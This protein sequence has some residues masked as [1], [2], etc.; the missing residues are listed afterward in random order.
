MIPESL[1]RVALTAL[2]VVL[3][4]AGAGC[5]AQVEDHRVRVEIEGEVEI[6]P[7]GSGQGRG[8]LGIV[9]HPDG[10]IFVNTQSRGLVR[11]TDNGRTWEAIEAE[12]AF[13]LGVT[14]DGR[15]WL[16][17]PKAEDAISV[18]YSADRGRSW[19]AA[20]V[21]GADLAPSSKRP[22]D[23]VGDDYNTFLE[24]PDGTLMLGVGAR[25]L[26]WYYQDPDLMQDGLVRPDADIGGLFLIRSTDGG[27]SWG[28]PTLMHPFVCEVGL[29]A[30]PFNPDRILAMTRIQ[31]PLLAGED[32][33]STLEKTGCPANVPSPE[34]SIYKNGLLLESLDRGRTFR[35]VPG[36]LTGYY[37]H[38]GTI[39]WTGDN[40]V[41]V[42]HQASNQSERYGALFA[43][44][45]LDGGKTWA[46]GSPSGTSRMNQSTRFEL[47]PKPPGHSFTAPT[48]ELSRDRFLTPYLHGS[49]AAGTATVT[50]VFWRLER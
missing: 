3:G 21:D 24:S 6:V 13:A 47:V 33:E 32:R 11:S 42:T 37:E 40:V 9:R 31:R 45:S 23:W 10:S 34:P 46:D 14:R 39:L 12:N 43:R 5:R 49:I 17:G 22:Y 38:R 27:A 2:F 1:E 29:A 48:L 8:M 25:N 26:P 4:A 16:A 18:S 44:I 30:D 28:D 15:L 35:E 36:S 50:G 19:T 20:M 7:P 41:V